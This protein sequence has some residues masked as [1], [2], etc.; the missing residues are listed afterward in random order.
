MGSFE[1]WNRRLHYYLGLYF[2]FFLWLF[3]LSGLLLNHGD[4]KFAQF[5]PM[6]SETTYEAGVTLPQEGSDLDR[7][8]AVMRQLGIAGEIDWPGQREAEVFA[9]N[10]N[11]PGRM[12]QVRVETATGRA[13]VK[14]I[15]VNAW[16]IVQ[17]LH[18]FSGVRM[19][20][21]EMSRDWALT[22]A[23]VVAMDA[24]AV[25]LI[26]MVLGGYYMWWRLR[27]KRR[28]GLLALA[29]GVLC[30]ALFTSGLLWLT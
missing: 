25:G 15:E 1:H 4:W 18:T 20:R 21:P 3:S 16:G 10:A 19:N 28:F 14:R 26:V 23:W 27:A 30:C 22:T 24:L 29:A 17:F 11:R 9:F 6:R 7:A 2:L 12:N 8:R 13:T 5:W